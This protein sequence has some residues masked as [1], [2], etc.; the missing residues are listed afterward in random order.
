MQ[1]L[2]QQDSSSTILIGIALVSIIRSFYSISAGE[3]GIAISFVGI[4]L[5]FAGFALI[6]RLYTRIYLSNDSD[7]P[8]FPLAQTVIILSGLTI[9]VFGMTVT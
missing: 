2:N 3:L 1:L 9:T 4:A 5:T 6:M 8:F 7:S